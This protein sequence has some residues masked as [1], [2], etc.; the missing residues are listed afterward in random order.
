MYGENTLA[1]LPKEIVKKELKSRQLKELKLDPPV[2]PGLVDGVIA[3]NQEY[4]ITP[5]AK[6]IAKIIQ[7][8]TADLTQHSEGKN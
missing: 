6:L 4:P 8:M 5:A 7:E 2:F 3:F 1:V